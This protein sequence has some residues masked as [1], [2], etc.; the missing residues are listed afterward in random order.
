MVEAI[1]PRARSR[2]RLT[3]MSPFEYI[4]ICSNADASRL[5]S[6]STECSR[7]RLRADRKEMI[8]RL[9]RGVAN[10]D[11]AQLI[12]AA[13]GGS[14]IVHGGGDRLERDVHDLQHAEFDI[15]LQR[16]GRAEVEGAE[17]VSVTSRDNRS[18]RETASSGTPAGTN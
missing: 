2:R 12:H 14:R 10:Q 11:A 16:A 6:G 8:L 18:P 1:S 5:E 15:L 13:D 17:Q 9:P 3:A 4:R 7:E